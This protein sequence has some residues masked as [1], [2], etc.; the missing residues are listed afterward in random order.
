MVSVN[1]PAG[2]TTL[3]SKSA[4]IANWR[5]G[6]LV[7]WDDG[8][9]LR[10]VGGWEQIVYALPFASRC[11]AMHRWV[12]LTG[13]HYIGYLCE[14]H[15]YVDDG[16][17]TLND[18]TPVGGMAAIAVVSGGY[19]EQSYSDI[20]YGTPRAGV[21]A[22]AKFSPAFSIN[23]WGE[24]LLVMTSFD[25]RLLR[26]SPTTPATK[27]TAVSG[28][29]TGNRQFVVTPEHHCMLF[30]MA[31][32]PA[33]FGWCS[34]EN[35]ND[36]NFAS[37]TNT[38]GMFTLDP[39]SP[40]LAAHSSSIGV[41]VSTP[42]MTHIVEWIGLPYVYRYRPIGKVPI[43]ISAASVSSI[44]LGIGWI[45]IEGFWLYN[46][47]TV[48]VI[49]CPVWDVIS[50]KMDFERTVLESHSISLLAKGE[51][52]WFWVDPEI[53]PVASR[54]IAIDYRS[55]VWM[56]GYLTRTCGFSYANDRFPVM[57]D[58]VKVWKHE[59]GFS[60]P[61]VLHMPYL[62]SQ[63]INVANG[64]RWCTINKILPEIMG[65]KNAL[66]FCLHKIN[67]RTGGV[68]MESPQYGVNEH[69]WV[70]MRETARDFRLSIEMVANSDWRTVGPIIFD[71]KP[72]GK[73]K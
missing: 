17:G 27:L 57:S 42:A 65:D 39:F 73:K 5:E 52:W 32:K 63:T 50:E 34:S 23:N 68:E 36:W 61:E 69:G 55:R 10:P 35:L 12:S 29:P 40:I 38:A 15:V 1:F 72:R 66:A 28:A 2:V 7:R 60:Y 47:S 26:W 70:D 11:R 64:E 43:P 16:S 53:S 62:E 44:P 18:V 22:I 8:V 46:G 71:I 25:G 31:G 54:Y 37:T 4:K 19:G 21:S 3:I 58:G 30:Q 45:S 67:D 56:S 13:L 41:L 6:N 9:T 49:P 14:Q 51:V 48:D 20:E 33:D 59:F 24:D